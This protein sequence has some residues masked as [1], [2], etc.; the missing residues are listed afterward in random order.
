MFLEP[1]SFNILT[2][3]N[4][5][6]IKLNSVPGDPDF[7]EYFVGRIKSD[8]TSDFEIHTDTES[9]V[10]TDDYLI[11]SIDNRLIAYNDYDAYFDFCDLNLFK[12]TFDGRY[13]REVEQNLGVISKKVFLKTELNKCTELSKKPLGTINENYIIHKIAYKH[14]CD[15]LKQTLITRIN[16]IKDLIDKIE[17]QQ[18]DESTLNLSPPILTNQQVLLLLFHF[19]LFDR[20]YRQLVEK[21]KS[22]SNLTR[23][24]QPIFP[25]IEHTTLRPRVNSIMNTKQKT[26]NDNANT[27][28]NRDAVKQFLLS[29]GLPAYGLDE[30]LGDT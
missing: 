23:I 13:Q 22:I 30:K 12:R 10:Y 19:G 5:E 11:E 28:S 16:F 17:N 27:P 24:L 6:D 9:V 3:I 29:H 7:N 21:E 8:L 1:N 20:I 25:N 26:H 4:M 15:A 14:I 2:K 18:V